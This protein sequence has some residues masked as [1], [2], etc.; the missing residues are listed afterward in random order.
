MVY[1][2]V[3]CY[4]EQVE[5]DFGNKGGFYRLWRTEKEK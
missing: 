4:N 5:S 3:W 2:G 1:K